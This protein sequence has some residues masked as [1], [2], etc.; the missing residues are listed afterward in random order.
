MPAQ[1]INEE[2]KMQGPKVNSPGLS[3][4][5]NKKG[6]VAILDLNEKLASKMHYIEKEVSKTI[7]FVMAE[8]ANHRGKLNIRLHSSKKQRSFENSPVAT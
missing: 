7:E 5:I 8:I 6:D 1:Y 3:P 4:I 2:E